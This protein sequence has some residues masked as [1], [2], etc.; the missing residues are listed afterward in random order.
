MSYPYLL[1]VAMCY[2]IVKWAVKEVSIGLAS[3]F[4]LSSTAMQIFDRHR[5]AVQ[6]YSASDFVKYFTKN[7]SCATLHTGCFLFFLHMGQRTL[8]GELGGL[9]RVSTHH[10]RLSLSHS[11]PGVTSSWL[12]VQLYIHS[13]VKISNFFS[14]ELVHLH[15]FQIFLQYY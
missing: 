5:V 11:Q 8:E 2:K 1:N 14:K 7:K 13:P 6:N 9:L 12:Q 15:G 3:M 4:P 10:Q